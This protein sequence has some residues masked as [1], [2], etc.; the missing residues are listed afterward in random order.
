MQGD[1][2]LN[3]VEISKDVLTPVHNDGLKEEEVKGV[4]YV[5]EKATGERRTAA[6]SIP[7][8]VLHSSF[9]KVGALI[10]RTSISLLLLV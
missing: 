3:A 1:L 9:T 2:H 8:S 6:D 4:K 10:E 5:P 7:S